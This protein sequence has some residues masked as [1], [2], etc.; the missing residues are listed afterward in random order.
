MTDTEIPQSDEKKVTRGKKQCKSCGAIVGVRQAVCECGYNFKEAKGVQAGQEKM[1]MDPVDHPQQVKIPAK[2]QVPDLAKPQEI[3][4][5]RRTSFTSSGRKR[6][7]YTPSGDCPVRPKGFSK[8][9]WTY[10]DDI[11]QEWAKETYSAGEYLPEAVIYFARYFWDINSE[12]FDRI[13]AL[14]LKA[15]P[16]PQFDQTE[17]I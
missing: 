1:T 8:E 14:I 5:T 11:V 2:I 16:K 7:I 10:T 6:T 17:E 4:E 3:V 13:E 15:L 12:E 9:K